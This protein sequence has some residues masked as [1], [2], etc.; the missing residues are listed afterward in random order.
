MAVKT[1]GKLD[2]DTEH[3]K[4]VITDAAPHVC[5]KIKDVFQRISKSD[6]VF[7]F[8]NTPENCTDILWFLDRYPMEVGSISMSI[9]TGQRS[10]FHDTASDLEQILVPDYKPPNTSGPMVILLRRPTHFIKAR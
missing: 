9:L 7:R 3:N 8:D 1:Y 4:W 5:I 10:V 6:T 2:L